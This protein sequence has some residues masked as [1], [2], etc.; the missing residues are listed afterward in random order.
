[1]NKP[2]PSLTF[3]S[4][5]VSSPFPSR[6]VPSA[7]Q[8]APPPVP[9]PPPSSPQGM[10]SGSSLHRQRKTTKDELET[11]VNTIAGRIGGCRNGGV[12]GLVLC[13]LGPLRIARSPPV[14]TLLKY[15]FLNASLPSLPRRLQRGVAALRFSANFSETLRLSDMEECTAK[16]WRMRW[17]CSTS[18]STEMRWP[19]ILLGNRLDSWCFRPALAAA[20]LAPSMLRQREVCIKVKRRVRCDNFVS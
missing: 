12:T 4:T 9:T 2:T 14:L 20:F 15:A 10:I 1:M 16:L 13:N 3:F 17:R 8:A 5:D 6:C 7:T 18:M 11:Q 19:S